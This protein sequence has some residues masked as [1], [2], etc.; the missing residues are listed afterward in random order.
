MRY[1]AQAVKLS[2]TEKRQIENFSIRKAQC[3]L[4]LERMHIL[5]EVR[6]QWGSEAHFDVWFRATMPELLLH[7]KR[8]HVYRARN[9]MGESFQFL[10]SSAA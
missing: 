3:T 5:E 6:A 10:F 4:P 7:A 9:I 2:N 1:G 8:R